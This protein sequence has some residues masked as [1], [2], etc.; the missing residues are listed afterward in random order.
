M[1]I[2]RYKLEVFDSMNYVVYKKKFIAKDGI[3]RVIDPAYFSRPNLVLPLKHIRNE[4]IDD[5]FE[6][7]EIQKLDSLLENVKRE[8]NIFI[9]RLESL[10]QNLTGAFS[11]SK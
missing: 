8:D 1:K 11:N 4:M 7:G 10:A 6:K 9:E 3:E 2:G 5:K